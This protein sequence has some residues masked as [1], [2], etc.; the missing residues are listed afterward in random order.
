MIRVPPQGVLEA[1]TDAEGALEQRRAVEEQCRGLLAE[2]CDSPHLLGAMVELLQH[3]LEGAE[4]QEVEGL[5]G[6]AEQLCGR[7]AGEV[8]VIRARYWTF[9]QDTVTRKYGRTD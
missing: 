7:L 9:V 2:G 6:E 5:V 8:D 3:R 1:A 4:E